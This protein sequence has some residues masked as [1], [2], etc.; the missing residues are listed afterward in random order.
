MTP[1]WVP[2]FTN[3][4]WNRARQIRDRL[5]FHKK[6]NPWI[7]AALVSSL[8]EAA[9]QPHAVGDNGQSFGPWQ[10]KFAFGGKVILAGVNID[11]RTNMDLAAQTDALVYLLS[12][13][14]YAKVSEELDAATNFHDANRAF[15]VDFERASAA[16]A[17][18]RRLDIG[19]RVDV[20]VGT[21]L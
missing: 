1:I 20:W 15:V 4:A 18:E 6:S 17:L 19:P 3:S 13:K 11:I 5:R 21:Q 14:P 16:G 9:W 12:T 10:I 8:G 7:V 2:P